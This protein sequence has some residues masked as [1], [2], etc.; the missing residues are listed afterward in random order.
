M[1]EKKKINFVTIHRDLKEKLNAISPSFCAAKWTQVSLHLHNG[2]THSCHHP[3]PHIVPLEELRK[4]PSALHNTNHKK[5]QRKL[6]LEGIRPKEC[7]YCWNVEGLPNYDSGTFFS[8]RITK[9]GEPWSRCKIDEIVKSGPDANLNPTYVEVNFSNI[10]NFKCSYCSP[11]FSSRWTEEIEKYGPYP[12]ASN[13]NNLDWYRKNGEMPIHHK[14]HNP[15]V[16]AF[17]KWW[18]DLVKD[19]QVLRITGGEPLL[20]DDTYKILDFLQKNPQPQLRLAINTNACSPN[21]KIDDF[22]AKA[23]QLLLEKK[24][25]NLDLFISIDS[26]GAPAEYG[27]FGLNFNQWLINVERFLVEFPT[28]KITIMSATNIFSVTKYKELLEI[29]LEFKRKYTTEIRPVAV[30]LDVAILTHPQHQ[31]VSILTDEYKNCMD[32]S[33]EFMKNNRVNKTNADGTGI[34]FLDY[35]ISRMERFVEFLKTKPK[36]SD[37]FNLETLQK[38]FYKFVNEHDRRRGTN[39]L[40]VF[41]ELLNFYNHCKSLVL[42]N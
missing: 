8:D 39:F 3:R 22:I 42:E 38:D 18:P 5:Q 12:M 30:S 13:Y 37:S 35:E 21:S 16:E 6:M 20:A 33:L 40:E 10:C 24:I 19:L 34:G 26:V 25:L 31:C 36:E 29:L 4:N 32:S 1:V 28:T 27:R 41:P 14:E 11:V 15:Y 7:Q 23:K 17:W 2:R 9:S